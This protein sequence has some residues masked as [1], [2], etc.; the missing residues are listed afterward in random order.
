MLLNKEIERKKSCHDVP[1]L[2]Y[3]GKSLTYIYI[4]IKKNGFNMVGWLGFMAYQPL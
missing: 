1:F 2:V 3:Y 4:Y